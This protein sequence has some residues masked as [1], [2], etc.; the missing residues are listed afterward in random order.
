MYSRC[1]SFIFLSVVM[2]FVTGCSSTRMVSS[3][4]PERATRSNEDLVLDDI[5]LDVQRQPT[6]K[7]DNYNKVFDNGMRV[8]RNVI[9]LNTGPSLVCSE[10]ETA[11]HFYEYKLGLDYGVEYQHFWPS[12]FGV[13]ASMY[14]FNASFDKDLNMGIKYMG[15]LVAYSDYLDSKRRIRADIEFGLGC[16]F[17]KEKGF[18]ETNTETDF[19]SMFGVGVECGVAKNVAFG[20][21]LNWNS[22]FMFEPKG[23]YIKDEDMYGIERWSLLAGVRVYF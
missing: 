10:V 2:L 7:M 21:Q 14:L 19:A 5:H 17:L 1:F 6:I 23:Y 15:P 20:L 4:E 18:Q 16:G 13:G 8:P 11:R 9:K 22:L 3:V 12:G